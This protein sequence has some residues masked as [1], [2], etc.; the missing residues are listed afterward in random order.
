VI[1]A[2]AGAAG[3]GAGTAVRCWDVT[4]NALTVEYNGHQ[5][6]CASRDSCER[7]SC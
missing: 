7:G 2:G 4:N 1:T 5:E 6:V 3:D